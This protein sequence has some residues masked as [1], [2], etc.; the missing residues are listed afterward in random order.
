MLNASV[1]FQR[2]LGRLR[3]PPNHRPSGV[4]TIR[5]Q[6]HAAAHQ[7]RHGLHSIVAASRLFPTRERRA[8]ATRVATRPTHT[9]RLTLLGRLGPDR[10]VAIAVAGI[11]LGASVVSVSAGHPAPNTGG[12]TGDGPGPR[13]AV[14]GGAAGAGAG[15]GQQDGSARVGSVEFG[16][17]DPTRDP[18]EEEFQ[19]VGLSEDQIE[20]DVPVSVEGPFIDDGTLV[21]PVAVDTTVPDGSDLVKTYKVKAGDTLVGIAAQVRRLDDD[22][23]VGE[24]SQVEGRSQGRPGPAHPAGH[25]PH[26][27]GHHGRHA[28]FARGPVRGPR[29]GHPRDERPDRPEPRGRADARGPGR[30]WQGDP[31]PGP[32]QARPEAADEVVVWRWQHGPRAGQPIPAASSCGRSSAA[33]TTSASTST[34]ATTPSTSRPTTARRC[35]RPEPGPSSSP[36]GR[37]TAAATRSGW[38]T[39]PGCTRP[40]TTCRRSRSGPASTSAAA[41]RSAESAN[42]AMRQDPTSTSKSGQGRSGTGVGASTRLAYL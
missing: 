27:P 22:R 13:I 4:R 35:A 40:T 36:A 18:Q 30:A 34:T 25:R 21:K 38:P 23:V 16:R 24:R 6:S 19:L 39:A 11:L 8:A 3:R 7:V 41:S 28:R 1:G 15:A 9:T 5:L 14:G 42:P 10:A 12:P 33:A 29:H 26:R 32:G 2:V 20:P 17:P 31:G 37:A